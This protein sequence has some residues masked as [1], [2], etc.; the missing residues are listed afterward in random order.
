MAY[1]AWVVAIA[2]LLVYEWYALR[3]HKM[4]LSRAVWTLAAKGPMFP[5]IVGFVAGVL[6]AHFFWRA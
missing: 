2:V 1:A 5:A 3:C 4:T 6:F